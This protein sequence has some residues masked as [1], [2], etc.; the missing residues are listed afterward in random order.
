VVWQVGPLTLLVCQHDEGLDDS[1]TQDQTLLGDGQGVTVAAT[2]RYIIGR[3]YDETNL[4]RRYAAV[5]VP[6]GHI[7]YAPTQSGARRAIETHIVA[8]HTPPQPEQLAMFA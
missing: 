1:M 5:C 8:E 6:W 3:C 2:R 4:S 7:E